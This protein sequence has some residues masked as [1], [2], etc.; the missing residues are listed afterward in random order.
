M[1]GPHGAFRARRMLR[2]VPSPVRSPP[3]R[4]LPRTRSVHALGKVRV[5]GGAASCTTT[6]RC[7]PCS[8]RLRPAAACLASRNAWTEYVGADV[9][10]AG[11]PGP[12][13]GSRPP[14]SVARSS[15]RA[16]RF[17]LEQPARLGD[18]RR[19]VAVLAGRDAGQCGELA[20]AEGRPSRGE[21][22]GHGAVVL[23]GM[24]GAVL[25]DGV[26]KQQVEDRTGRAVEHAV[27]VDQGTGAG[28]VVRLDGG[29]G[30]GEQVVGLD[31]ADLL[32]VLGERIRLRVEP[33]GL[34]RPCG[35]RR[36]SGWRTC[37]G[38]R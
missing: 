19:G 4:D 34:A 9:D 31:G 8:N 21:L 3:S 6:D 29:L 16:D 24:Q 28:L 11:K 32:V 13:R 23:L 38:G 12:T 25:A 26:A 2:R 1:A 20:P 27:A 33:A 18:A 14:S 36:R 17:D 10:N 35:R 5:G 30:L 15:R 37:C 7:G 22:L